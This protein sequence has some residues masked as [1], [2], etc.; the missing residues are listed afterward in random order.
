[1]VEFTLTGDQQRMRAVDG[2]R[3]CARADGPGARDERVVMVKLAAGK[4]STVA[5]RSCGP[6][7]AARVSVRMNRKRGFAPA[8]R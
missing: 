5:M 2:H 6:S 7:P 4:R 3:G 8:G 1:M